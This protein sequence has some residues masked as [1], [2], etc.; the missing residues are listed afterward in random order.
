MEPQGGTFEFGLFRFDPAE[1]VLYRGAQRVPLS[2]KVADTLFVLLTHHGRVVEKNELMQLVWPDTFVEEGGLARNISALRKAL[3]GDA[4]GSGYIET[5]PKRGYRFVA[6]L[7]KTPTEPETADTVVGIGAAPRRPGVR[8]AIAA[9]LVAAAL[10]LVATGYL[11]SFMTRHDHAAPRVKSI[12]VLPLKNISGDAAQDYFAEGMTEVI[13]TE[14]S[15]TGLPVIAPASVRSLRPGAPLEEVGRQLKVEAVIQGTVLQ[16][17]DRVRI[18][19]QLVDIGS[20][21]LLW[22][23]SYQRDLRDVL[24]LQAEVAGAIARQ[25]SSQAAAGERPA[26]SRLQPVVPTPTRRTCG[27][28]SS[29]TSAPSRRC[30]RLS[31]TSTKRLR[32]T[33]RTPGLC[34]AGRFLG[35]AGFQ[36]VRCGSPSR[37]HATGE[38]R[39]PTGVGTGRRA[40]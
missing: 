30:E 26:P 19:A 7:G 27:D 34:G 6:P 1:R 32:K 23:D 18:N 24:R 21:R 29:G 35:A 12:A 3:G 38:G 28:V 39:R 10:L 14:L 4:E 17:G 22:A 36:L 11:V 16:S 13:A 33:G 20:G 2:P 37:G 8:F 25:T 5:I 15:K 31:S 40:G 9:I